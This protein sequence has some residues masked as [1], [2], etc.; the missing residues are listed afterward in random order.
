[1]TDALRAQWL[2]QGAQAVFFLP[3]PYKRGDVR[4]TMEGKSHFLRLEDSAFWDAISLYENTALQAPPPGDD[5]AARLCTLWRFCEG[6]APAP[7]DD[8]DR[9]L[10]RC[11]M[12]LANPALHEAFCRHA[13][14]ALSE[15]KRTGASLF[16]LRAALACACKMRENLCANLPHLH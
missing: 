14:R 11:A 7:L 2:A 6:A 15:K 12:D 5:L 8:A 9:F 4:I 13:A 1:M 16:A 3:Y 10:L